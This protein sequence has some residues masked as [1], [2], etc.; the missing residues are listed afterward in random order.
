MLGEDALGDE[1]QELSCDFLEFFLGGV[2]ICTV[3]LVEIGSREHGGGESVPFDGF[4]GVFYLGSVP[5]RGLVREHDSMDN[6]DLGG[7]QGIG[8]TQDLIDL[9]TGIE[10]LEDIV[11]VP[12]HPPLREAPVVSLQ[13]YLVIGCAPDV[14][15][16]GP[17]LR[18]GGFLGGVKHIRGRV[19]AEGIPLGDEDFVAG[20][21][22]GGERGVLFHGVLLP[23][24]VRGTVL[25]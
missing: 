8:P 5:E 19:E 13:G 14:E 11:A 22:P 15:E 9:G 7:R 6:L 17:D 1:A 24:Q 4:E 3:D 25:P 2:D 18:D 10:E 16:L 20:F 12:E 21:D 23:I